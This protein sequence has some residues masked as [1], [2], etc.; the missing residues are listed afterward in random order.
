MGLSLLPFWLHM[1]VLP[2]AYPLHSSSGSAIF[3]PLKNEMDPTCTENSA[4]K[5]NG[6]VE[7]DS[8]L[9]LLVIRIS[10]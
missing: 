1:P 3:S 4:L 8:E 10:D 6:I 2:I 5:D 9:V 7:E